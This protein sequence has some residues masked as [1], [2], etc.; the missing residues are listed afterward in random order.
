MP[1][2][3]SH[4]VLFPTKKEIFEF[5]EKN[6]DRH[7]IAMMCRLYNVTRDGYNSW[8][9]R[10]FS[11]RGQEDS[12]L[13]LLIKAVFDKHTECYGSPKITRELRKQGLGVGQKRV[14]RIMR[15]HGLKAIK[16]KIYKARPGMHRHVYRI[17]CRIENIKLLRENQLWVGDV[18]YI[19]LRDGRWQYLA[20]IMDRYSRRIIAWSL[21]DT[22]DAQ[23]TLACLERAVRNRGYHKELIFHSDRGV[24]YL[25]GHYQERLRRYGISQSMNRV[26][27]M[28][29]NAFIESFFQQFKTE[30][31]KR[32]VLKTTDQLRGLIVEYMRYY[33][34]ERSHSSIG[35]RTPCEFECR[36]EQ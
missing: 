13:Y 11:L 32:V 7:T 20:V 26:K 3:K 16:A 17:P 2:K 18:T 4:P 1:F 8:R 22:R 36:I 29:D 31:I 21:S 35:Y 5:I 34:F 15:E 33:N 9:R 14:A 19:K 6:K 28:N 30:R 25:A 24:E 10:G 12:K 23:L 27:T